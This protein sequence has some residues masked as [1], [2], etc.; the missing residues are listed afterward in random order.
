[1]VYTFFIIA[2][3]WRIKTRSKKVSDRERRSHADTSR[4]HAEINNIA[5]STVY[6]FKYDVIVIISV[7]ILYSYTLLCEFRRYTLAEWFREKKKKW[8]PQKLF[9]RHHNNMY[10][11]HCR[12]LP[13][14]NAVIRVAITIHVSHFII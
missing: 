6:T 2:Q 13:H 11:I 8:N 4:S 7:I 14:A 3:N 9:F 5:A 1:M 12:L 10:R